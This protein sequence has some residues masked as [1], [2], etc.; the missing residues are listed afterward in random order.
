LTDIQSY[1][2]IIQLF[3]IKPKKKVTLYL[4]SNSLSKFI[5]FN[6]R[7][8][9][10]GERKT[11]FFLLSKKMILKGIFHGI[12]FR[13]WLGDQNRPALSNTLTH[14]SEETCLF[15]ISLN[16]KGHNPLS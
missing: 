7:F 11:G 2:T 9:F 14:T 10:R 6:N 15:S 16:W 8:F 3:T 5:F 13:H 12:V 1:P 4:E